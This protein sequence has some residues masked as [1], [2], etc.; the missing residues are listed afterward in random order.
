[1]TTGRRRNHPRH[2]PVGVIVVVLAGLLTAAPALARGA[3]SARAVSYPVSFQVLNVN[4]SLDA[5]K[6]DGR[7]YTVAGHIAGPAGLL[8]ARSIS[9]GALYLHGDAVDESLWRFRAVPGYDYAAALARHGF[10]SVTIDRLGYGTSGRP[11]GNQVC[12]GSEADVAHQIIGQLKSG[13]Y[14]TTTA[15]GRPRGRR[16]ARIARIALVG[17]SAAGYIAMDEA[18]SFRDVDALAV[19]ASGEDFTPVVP[20]VLLGQQAGCATS[21]NGY[22]LLNSTDAQARADFFHDADPAVSNYAVAHRPP[23]ACEGTLDSP[24]SLTGDVAHL[25]SVTVPVLCIAGQNDAFYPY[26]RQQCAHFTA[27]RR[28]SAVALPDTG[29]AITLGRSAPQFQAAMQTWLT[30]NGFHP[31]TPKTKH[32]KKKHHHTRGY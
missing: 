5:C 2:V 30:T 12:W 26:P 22:A 18:Y 3:R 15:G 27:S 19:V 4:R 10:V 11:N 17:H 32:H 9:A 23:D 20:T 29:H 21:P 16:S 6:P 28:V 24:T 13:T 1:M 8:A 31:T 14:A 7:P 25:S